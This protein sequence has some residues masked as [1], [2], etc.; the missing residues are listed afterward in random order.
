MKYYFE[1]ETVV[2][3]TNCYRRL[4]R[5]DIMY[6][7]DDFAMTASGIIKYIIMSLYC[8]RRSANIMTGSALKEKNLVSRL[9]IY[10]TM[11]TARYRNVLIYI[12]PDSSIN[13]RII[14]IT[15]FVRI[16]D[17]TLST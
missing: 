4:T 5:V 11:P 2:N 16:G 17:S 8:R 9:D 1:T 6:G 7:S 14:I 13:M 10:I 12:R 3:N 15:M